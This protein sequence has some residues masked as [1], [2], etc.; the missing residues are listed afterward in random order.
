MSLQKRKFAQQFFSYLLGNTT[1]CLKYRETHSILVWARRVRIWQ[2]T[3]TQQGSPMMKRL[4]PQWDADI[5]NPIIP[6][7]NNWII[8]FVMN[9]LEL[10][11]TVP[12]C[13]YPCRLPRLPRAANTILNL[14]HLKVALP[15]PI[16]FCIDW[17]RVGTG[18]CTQTAYLVL[19]LWRRL[20]KKNQ[21][22]LKQLSA[23]DKTCQQNRF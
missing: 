11:W 22:K 15:N 19:G 16:L 1:D 8:F 23:N 13:R 10:L 4:E 21:L 2:E 9:R 6:M 3:E 7:Y 20:Q 17:P 18:I 12:A 14:L 5:L